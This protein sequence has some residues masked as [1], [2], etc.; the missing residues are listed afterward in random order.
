MKQNKSTE[1]LGPSFLTIY[2]KH[3]TPDP[4]PDPKS[5]FFSDFRGISMGSQ[6]FFGGFG[7]VEAWSFCCVSNSGGNYNS[8]KDKDSTRRHLVVFDT[9]TK[10]LSENELSQ[11][12]IR[13]V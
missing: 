3:G 1:L 8:Q 12:V 7:G 13:D 9:D 5:E 2:N 11:S 6:P 4:A 10:E